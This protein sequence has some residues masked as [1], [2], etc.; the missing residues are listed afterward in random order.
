MY[1]K[2]NSIDIDNTSS[3]GAY[4]INRN[5]MNKLR[6]YKVSQHIDELMTTHDI[7]TYKSK[8]NLFKTDESVSLLRDAD[9]VHWMSHFVPKTTCGEKTEKDRFS[10]KI[11]RLGNT[12]FSTGTIID[13]A[14][15]LAVLFVLLFAF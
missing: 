8:Y 7:K 10:N 11:L 14:V 12:E 1:C 4:I 15:F 9:N 3:A 2:Y 5:G 13:M 6:K